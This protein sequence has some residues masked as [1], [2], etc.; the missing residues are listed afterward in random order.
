MIWEANWS[1]CCGLVALNAAVPIGDADL[2]V[3]LTPSV[4]N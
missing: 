2:T 1:V 3:T 4:P